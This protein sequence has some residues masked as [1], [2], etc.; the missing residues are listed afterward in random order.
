MFFSVSCVVN[1]CDPQ[2]SIFKMT[3]IC[4]F[5]GYFELYQLLINMPFHQ[6]CNAVC[7]AV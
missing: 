2:F 5:V 3:S 6:T 1:D 7:L 4:F